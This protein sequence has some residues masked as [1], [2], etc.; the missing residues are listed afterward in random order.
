MAALPLAARAPLAHRARATGRGA[1]GDDLRGEDAGSQLSRRYQDSFPE[2]YKED[3]TPRTASVDLGRLEAIQGEEGVDHSL[4]Q[5]L[6]AASG[7]A[8]LKIY[9]IGPPLS[10]SELLGR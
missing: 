4:Y 1:H 10:L 2:A 8:R 7:E 6:D 9:R 5:D 3:F